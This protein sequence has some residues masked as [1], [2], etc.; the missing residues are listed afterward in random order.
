MN[1]EFKTKKFKDTTVYVLE[2]A[3]SGGTSAGSVASNTGSIGSVQ[4][5]KPGQNLIAQESNKEKVPATKPRN[6]VAKNATTSGAGAHKDKKKA[7]KQGDVKHKSREM[8]VAEGFGLRGT[9]NPG[10]PTPYDQGRADAKKGRPYDNPYD[11]PGEEQEHRN[12]RKGY[13]QGK[14]QGVAEEG[15]GNDP[16]QRVDPRTGKKYVPPKSPLG[17]GVA[18]GSLEELA[19]TSLDVKEPKDMYNVNDRKQTTYKLFKF[20]S[21][22]N[23]FLIKFTVKSPPTLGKKQNW[24]AVN[25][26][27]GVKEKQDDYSFGDEMNTDLTARNKNQFLIYSTVINTV[28]K[29]ITEYNTEIDEIIMQG[30]GERQEAMYQRFF[31][32][33]GKYFPGWHHD[34]KHSLVRDVPRQTGK[35]V[36]E[37][38]VAEGWGMGGYDTY[39]ATNHGRGVAENPE[40]YNDEANSMSS[41]QLKSLVKHA[42]KLRHAVKQMQAQ[43]DTLEPWQQ[44]K[45]TKAA[46]YLDA[47]FNAVD[48]EHDMDESN[49]PDEKEDR[50]LI[51]QM[52]KKAALKQEQQDSYMESLTV[53]LSEKLKANDPVE[54]YIN[55]FEKASKTPNAKGHHQFKSKSKEKVRQMAI[56]ASYGAKNPIKKK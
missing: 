56:A 44:S 46:D 32:S 48:D 38:G 41:A 40:W 13:E 15:Y 31:Q 52:V 28:R 9:G 55:D 30:A 19:N 10:M 22:K 53:Q 1:N 54:K 17:Q 47:V 18:E 8:D 25:V 2:S 51:R 49:H 34:G 24:N 6:F 14:Q 20:K 29:F 16:S 36:R 3:T 50:A 45:V 11:Q 12:Y 42:A 33:A 35:K 23:T 4:R 7:A 39:S 43:G 5:R 21:G 27:F 26:A 37:Q